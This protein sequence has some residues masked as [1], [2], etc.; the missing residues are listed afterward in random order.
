[1]AVFGHFYKSLEI[2]F[3]NV[4]KG[5]DGVV[6]QFQSICRSDIWRSHS[7]GTCLAYLTGMNACPT[8]KIYQTE[9]VLGMAAA[10]ADLTDI[11]SRKSPQ[12]EIL[13]TV[14]QQGVRKP[15]K[16]TPGRT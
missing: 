1:M 3:F 7:F 6:T 15:Q 14:S 9:S 5:R 4:K 10:F 2:N 11:L 13:G 8:Q 16:N 12:A